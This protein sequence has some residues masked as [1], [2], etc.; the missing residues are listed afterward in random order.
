MVIHLEKVCIIPL[1]LKFGEGYQN[2]EVHKC[3]VS[4]S[5][6]VRS[7]LLRETQTVT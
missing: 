5:R 6:R 1:M 3:K 4:N 2:D 7:A